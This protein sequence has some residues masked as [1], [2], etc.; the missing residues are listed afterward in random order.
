MRQVR[1]DSYYFTE[2]NENIAR[3]FND[4]R[5]KNRNMDYYEDESKLSKEEL[6]TRNLRFAIAV[7]KKFVHH[8]VDFEDLVQA[9]NIGLI[10]AAETYDPSTGF[11]FISYAVWKIRRNILNIINESRLGIRTNV[12]S[13]ASIPKYIDLLNKY[14]QITNRL[15]SVDDVLTMEPDSIPELVVDAIKAQRLTHM[16]DPIYMNI[17]SKSDSTNL[18]ETYGH[19]SEYETKM[20]NDNLRS[21]LFEMMDKLLTEDEKE[22]II[23]SVYNNETFDTIAKR[24]GITRECVRQRYSKAIKKFQCHKE[25]LLD[26]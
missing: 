1:T 23:E 17:G 26:K 7:A 24:H 3:Y 12:R 10:Q 20:N 8:G 21:R 19:E 5:Q 9:A 22:V 25:Y 11:K 14:S 13:I 18:L 15:M 4:V 2:R 16:E 6:I